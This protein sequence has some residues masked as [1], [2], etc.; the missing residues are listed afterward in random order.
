MRDT[1]IRMQVRQA[2]EASVCSSWRCHGFR[3]LDQE[4][5]QA[6]AF[7]RP[8]GS[9]L[10]TP[11]WPNI[12]HAVGCAQAMRITCPRPCCGLF[13]SHPSQ[14]G[15]EPVFGASAG[16]AAAQCQLR[17]LAFLAA[18]A[19]LEGQ[20]SGCKHQRRGNPCNLRTATAFLPITAIV[21][22]RGRAAAEPVCR[23]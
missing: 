8:R 18:G 21:G 23:C 5:E 16:A 22:Q 14:E 12:C 7:I 1:C 10:A 6:L 20:R 9:W 4:V 15:F 3:L 19:G 11:S 17:Y 2:S 13:R